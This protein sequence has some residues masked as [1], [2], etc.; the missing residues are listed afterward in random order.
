MA[1]VEVQTAAGLQRPGWSH[2][3]L[4]WSAFALVSA[5]W[6]SAAMFGGYVLAFYLGALPSGRLDGWNQNLPRLYEP[7]HPAAL[8]S[9][10][11]HFATGAVLLLLG[12]V[13]LIGGVRRRW[14]A[15][16]RWTGRLYVIAAGVAGLGGLLFIFAKG[17]IGGAPM[18]L[19]FGLYGALV[20]L[21]AVE[22]YRHARDRRLASHRAWAIRLFALAT[23]SWLYR[24][25]YG[26]WLLVGHGAGHT[27]AFRGPFDVV[28][29]FFFY[30]PNLLIAEVFIRGSRAPAHS[31]TRVA[32][33]MALNFATF[34]VALGTY[35]F[36]RYY[37]GPA[38]LHA[39][40]GS[41]G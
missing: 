28:M 30:I 26:F 2:A 17:T 8:V 29:A 13:Q 33:S 6:F 11:A 37:W 22:T 24:M 10:A 35:Y 23:G 19:G 16:H 15:F 9:I 36:G 20:T 25:E 39:V 12:P 7:G 27:D 18:N 40:F 14:P 3:N 21:A 31:T 32:A 4:R 1:A 41:P 34:L 5:S 38:I